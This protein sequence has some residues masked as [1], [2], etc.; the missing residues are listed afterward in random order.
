MKKFSYED[1][2]KKATY[3]HFFL[4]FWILEKSKQLFAFVAWNCG[5]FIL[6]ILKINFYLL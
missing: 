1:K 4:E 6:I 3:L 2:P 5:A